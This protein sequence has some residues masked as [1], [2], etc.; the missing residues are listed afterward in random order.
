MNDPF[1]TSG[2][3]APDPARPGTGV[4]ESIQQALRE[5]GADRAGGGSGTL[6]PELLAQLAQRVGLT[7]PAQ[8]AN[9]SQMLGM[10]TAVAADAGVP[11]HI[12]FALGD[13]DCAFPSEA[14]QGVERVGDVTP[15]PN[16]APWVLGILNL[17]G[18]I[19]S[20]VDLRGF[21]DMQP[22][23]ITPRT[24][25]LVLSSRDMTIGM[26][27]DGVTEM[28][29]LDGEQAPASSPGIVPAWAAP[30]VSRAITLQD[31]TILLLDPERLLFAEKMH[32][33]RADFS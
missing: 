29:T 4:T 5:M 14:V 21:F 26:V 11:Q 19:T 32:R 33:Y 22:Q 25:L 31:R 23:P 6:T 30:Y 27:V 3:P 16:T 8:I 2:T 10:N 7:N 13:A 1:P 17:H 9:L 15:V 12:I 20:V 24:R 18:A 28:L